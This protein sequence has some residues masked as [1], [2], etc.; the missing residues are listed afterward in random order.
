MTDSAINSLIEIWSQAMAA[1]EEGFKKIN[2]IFTALNI[3]HFTDLGKKVITTIP[4]I[5]L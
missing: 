4:F 5:C 1:K 2:T 3:Y